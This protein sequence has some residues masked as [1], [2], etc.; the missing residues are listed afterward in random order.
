[1]MVRQLLTES[2]LLSMIGGSLGVVLAAWGVDALPA[3][4]PSSL[5]RAEAIHIDMTVLA[6]TLIL[7]VLTGVVFGMV[8]AWHLLREDKSTMLRDN[9]RSVT[10]GAAGRQ[11]RRVLIGAE[12]AIAVILVIGAGL[13]MRSFARL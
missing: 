6:G 9:S 3:I 1:R 13:L 2:V 5:P 4:N 12:V 7:A 11:F 8:P 10:A